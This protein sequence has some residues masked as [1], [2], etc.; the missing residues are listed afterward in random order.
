LKLDEY[1]C[2]FLAKK[3]FL[4]SARRNVTLDKAH[5][6]EGTAGRMHPVVRLTFGS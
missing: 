1:Y 5:G 3:E 6:W 2:L 4:T